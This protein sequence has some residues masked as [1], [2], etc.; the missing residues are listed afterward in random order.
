MT[1][2][3]F[4]THRL[5]SREVEFKDSFI[6]PASTV[7]SGQLNDYRVGGLWHKKYFPLTN[8]SIYVQTIYMATSLYATA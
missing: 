3:P 1:G 8:Y 5:T 4:I 2:I 7:D 6:Y